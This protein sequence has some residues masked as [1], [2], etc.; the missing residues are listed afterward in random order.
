[1]NPN[2]LKLLDFYEFIYDRQM[3][4]HKRFVEKKEHPWSTDPILS[5]YKFCNVY[6]ELDKGSIYLIDTI[7]NNKKLSLADKFLNCVAYRRFNLPGF[8]D[9]IG[10]PM[11]YKKFA[12]DK[13]IKALD[14]RKEEGHNLF[15][16]AYIVSQTPY[17]RKLGRREKH[18]QQL[19]VLRDLAKDCEEFMYRGDIE[20]A[21][22]EEIHSTFKELIFGMG[23][24]LAYQTCI[25]L[26]Y[27]PE[28]KEQFEDVGSFVAMGPGSRP[29]VKLLFPGIKSKPLPCKHQK[30]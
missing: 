29:G 17:D 9:W 5:T 27:F 23:D 3:I 28:F 19:T 18:C 20:N 6:R 26:T 15:N 2:K 8:F 21:T 4:W 12:Y 13:Y 1:M 25:D 10:G 14:K 7:I 24:F 11:S 22:L 16:D 30:V